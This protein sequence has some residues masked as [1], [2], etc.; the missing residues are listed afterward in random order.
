MPCPFF[1]PV[2]VV[3]RPEFPGARLPLLEEHEGICHA[4]QEPFAAPA[5][6]RFRCCNH[7]YSRDRCEHFPAAEI[8]SAI[9][10]DVLQ[11]DAEEIEI[12]CVEERDYAPLRWQK[13]RYRVAAGVIEPELPDACA[14]AQARAF[15]QSLLRRFG[16][17][18]YG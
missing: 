5:E 17:S 15:C 8:R 14:R 10:F 2:R 12:L 18:I 4:R 6:L 7:G 13:L 16:A 1:E 3:S 11:Q 9:R